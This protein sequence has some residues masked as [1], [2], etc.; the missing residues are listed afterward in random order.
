MIDSQEVSEAGESPGFAIT[1]RW[2]GT[3]LTFYVKGDLDLATGP[4]VVEGIESAMFSRQV[5]ACTVQL[6]LAGVDFLDARGYASLRAAVRAVRLNGADCTLTDLSEP[7]AR[8]FRLVDDED[9]SAII[10]DAG[11][12][13]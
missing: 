11:L 12:R 9:L 5:P 4:Y 1:A 3:T 6:D 2:V 7:V 10:S 8:L 13:V